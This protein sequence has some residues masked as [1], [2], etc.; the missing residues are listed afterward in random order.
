M[1]LHTYKHKDDDNIRLA[2]PLTMVARAREPRIPNHSARPHSHMCTPAGPQLILCDFMAVDIQRINTAR[3]C[4]LPF[5]LS[6]VHGLVVLVLAPG[7]A[8][9]STAALVVPLHS[10]L[11]AERTKTHIHTPTYSNKKNNV[12]SKH[13]TIQLASVCEC[14]GWSHAVAYTHF[15]STFAEVMYR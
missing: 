1:S 4:R 10:G 7:S 6:M 13:A 5:L 14:M 9:T 11:R 2:D 3:L 8:A 12:P 15:P